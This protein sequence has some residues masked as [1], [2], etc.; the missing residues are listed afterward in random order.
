MSGWQQS[1]EWGSVA[2]WI[3]GA[4]TVGALVFA[5]WQIRRDRSATDHALAQTDRSLQMQAERDQRNVDERLRAQAALTTCRAQHT[6][7]GVGVI[8]W[9]QNHSTVPIYD[10]EFFCCHGDGM[11]AQ[12]F[13]SPFVP[14]LN[15]ASPAEP[16][17]QFE[18]AVNRAVPAEQFCGVTFR[19]ND[20]RHWIRW[21]DGHLRAGRLAD[22]ARLSPKDTVITPEHDP[23]FAT[24]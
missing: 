1:I 15:N 22:V 14:P 11:V 20:G 17:R 19:D 16:A 6:P 10:L 2:E 18:F 13:K 8:V 4:G 7:N 9:F 21:G 5:G 3:A 12:P 24:G 23:R